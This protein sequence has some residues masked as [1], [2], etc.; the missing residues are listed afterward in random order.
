MQV[1][2]WIKQHSELANVPVVFLTALVEEGY[3][4][5]VRRSGCEGFI[6]KPFTNI[7]LLSVIE[8]HIN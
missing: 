3:K 6:S 2:N 4:E 7:D 5:K 1:C 8:K